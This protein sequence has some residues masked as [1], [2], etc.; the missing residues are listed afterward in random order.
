M[1]L[2]NILL[3]V[4]AIFITIQFFQIDK[5]TSP[6]DPTKDFIVLTQ[7][8]EEL[9]KILQTACYDCHSNQTVYPWYSYISPV[10]WW[11]KHHVEEGTEHL[12]FS[13]WADYSAKKA[14]HKLEEMYEEVEEGEMPLNSYTWA[15]GDA[16]LTTEQREKLISWV[17][18]L[19]K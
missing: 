6:V 3:G 7:P 10:N 5:S 18:S 13:N 14:D 8:D 11:L 4:V 12:N 16:R 1:T 17:Q 19:R 2:K 9:T 15:H